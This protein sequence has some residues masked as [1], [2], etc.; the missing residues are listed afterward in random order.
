[1]SARDTARRLLYRLLYQAARH[2]RGTR[3]IALYHTVGKSRPD[4]VSVGEFQQQVALLASKFDVVPLCQLRLKMQRASARAN[5]ACV[6]FDDGYLD[7]YTD[8]APALER[9]S[10]KA[11]FFVATGA[12][13]GTLAGVPMMTRSQIRELA[14][15][16]H[17]I[18]AHSVS[19]RKL[20][21]LPIADV[22][23][24]MSESRARLEDLVGRP[25]TSFAYPYGAFTEAVRGEAEAAGFDVAATVRHRLVPPD[26]D[27][28]ALPRI[29]TGAD[30]STE[31]V[32]AYMSWATEWYDAIRRVMPGS[33]SAS[34][35][36]DR[37]GDVAQ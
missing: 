31:D 27:W 5:I 28:L 19:H 6:T 12:L 1:M 22:R 15:L 2:R 8:A 32:A 20:P 17:E 23:R 35:W 34:T 21:H 7:N 18:G 26:P 29:W 4:S 10:V 36:N 11:T 3:A 9:H 13:G 25:V 24:E 14:D 37:A 30:S 16:G 33:D